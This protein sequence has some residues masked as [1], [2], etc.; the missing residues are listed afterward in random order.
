M[1]IFLAIFSVFKALR[2][3]IC[4]SGGWLARQLDKVLDRLGVAFWVDGVEAIQLDIFLNLF[5]TVTEFEVKDSILSFNYTF[6]LILGAATVVMYIIMV[7][8]DKGLEVEVKN[9]PE[10]L[11]ISPDGFEAA[12][13]HSFSLKP[14]KSELGD[15]S[16]AESHHKLEK[17]VNSRNGGL[18][19][20]GQS[21]I[22]PTSI[23]SHN[24]QIKDTRRAKNL[25]LIRN[26][27]KLGKFKQA[28]F[29]VLFEDLKKEKLFQRNYRSFCALR[30]FGVSM[31]VILLHD[32]PKIQVGAL[33]VAMLGFTALECVYSPNQDRKENLMEKCRGLI[34]T[35]ILVLF[36][37]LLAGSEGSL[38]KKEQYRYI[39][40]PVII[41]V[42]L[43]FTASIGK[44]LYENYLW[45]KGMCCGGQNEGQNDPKSPGKE[46]VRGRIHPQ[47]SAQIMTNLNKIEPIESLEIPISGRKGQN[48]K[49]SKNPKN[50]F[51]SRKGQKNEEIEIRA[52]P[53]DDNGRGFLGIYHPAKPRRRRRHFKFK[54]PG[55]LNFISAKREKIS[56]KRRIRL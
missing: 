48:D 44:D 41:L 19:P 37:A 31:F 45:V 2:C 35:A 29:A 20:S 9:E 17:S 26:S 32:Y 50:S 3:V 54:K 34:Y 52:E 55:N 33:L 30:D 24:T 49:N 21:Q 13:D 56:R 42:V 51:F 36:V 5:I 6:S 7:F 53:K 27:R 40:Y 12:R 11:K 22:P 1:F 8:A 28:R 16:R 38:T 46:E 47:K 4:S 14:P 39:G 25:K 10:E 15:Q 18:N 43:L 23:R